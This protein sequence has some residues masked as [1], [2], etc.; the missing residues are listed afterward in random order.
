MPASWSQPSERQFIAE[1]ESIGS[2]VVWCDTSG[3]VWSAEVM[4]ERL[5]DFM[6]SAAAKSTVINAA[7]RKLKSA[8][9]RLD[10]LER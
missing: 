9:R 4:G 6:T 3:R 2:L 8:L 10:E 5:G 7:R 1:L